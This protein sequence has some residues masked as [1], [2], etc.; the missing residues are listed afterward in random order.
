[1]TVAFDVVIVAYANR[2]EIADC[3]TRAQRLP[4][5]GD[6][7]VVDHGSDGAADVAE[8]VG[9][10]VLRDP[11]NPGFGSGQN[12]GVTLTSAPYVL[13]LNPDAVPDDEGI[14]AGLAVLEECDDVA[15]VQGVITNR[16]TGVPERSRGRE[17]GPV[18]L[19]GRAVGARRLLGVAPVRA[20]A[21]RVGVLAD[22]VDRVPDAPESVESLAA[23]ALL[24]RR[25]AFDA[26]GGFD[27]SYFLYGEDLDLCRRFRAG[28]WTLLALP[29][30]FAWHEGGASAATVTERELTWW[31]G[32]MRFSALWWSNAAWA[33]ALVASLLEWCSLSAREPR[34][35]RRAWGALLA[36]PV[37]DRRL[38]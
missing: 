8:A 9:A 22:H 28:G 38:R 14:A 36:A 24:V 32:T 5:V 6:V 11:S 18:H 17:L 31:R 10:R 26:I 13:L 21:R 20:M 12:H 30:R 33:G 25:A 23:T 19:L 35:A 27:E 15:A 16:A 7:I 3:V 29:D 1:M 2:D 4:G 37:R 34:V